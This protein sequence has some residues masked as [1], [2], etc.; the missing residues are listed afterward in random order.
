MEIGLGG[1]RDVLEPD[2]ESLGE[3]EVV[4]GAQL[5]SNGFDLSEASAGI[6]ELVLGENNLCASVALGSSKGSFNPTA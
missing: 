3:V 2:V 1:I 4:V 5:E 6:N